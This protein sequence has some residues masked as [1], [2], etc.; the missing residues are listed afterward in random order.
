MVLANQIETVTTGEITSFTM[1]I[2][3]SLGLA[4][5]VSFGLIRIMFNIPLY[6]ILTVLYSIVFILAIFTTPEFLATLLTLLLLPL[7]AGSTIYSGASSCPT[8]INMD[9]FN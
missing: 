1:L 3:V 8:C 5:M 4:V 7:G 6:I 2:V 9:F